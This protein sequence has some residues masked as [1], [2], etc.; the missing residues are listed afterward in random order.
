M[1]CGRGEAHFATARI[2]RSREIEETILYFTHWVKPCVIICIIHHRICFA[3]HMK[4][5]Q[6]IVDIA[7]RRPS[8]MEV[9]G[10]K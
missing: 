3:I 2:A 6:L 5:K 8:R 9:V 7:R 1:L 10:A 4:C